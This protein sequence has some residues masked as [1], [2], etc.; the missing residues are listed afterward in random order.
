MRLVAAV[1]VVSVAAVLVSACSSGDGRSL[2]PA[3]EPLPTTTTTTPATIPGPSFRVVAPW[4]SDGLVPARSGCGTDAA[5]PAVSW[6]DVPGG[7]SELAVVFSIDGTPQ[8]VL[9]GIDPVAAGL[10]EGALPPGSFWWPPSDTGARWPGWCTDDGDADLQI[11]VYALNQQLEA[12]DDTS[13]T[14]LV[15]MIAMT[16]ITQ[17]TVIGRLDVPSPT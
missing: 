13:V 6:T 8:E 9:V 15:G 10:A 2:P 3:V 12:A 16:A 17:A 1:A 4:G 11:T 5:A 7:T 14:E